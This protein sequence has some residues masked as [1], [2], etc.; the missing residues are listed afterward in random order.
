MSQPSPV[1]RT[2]GIFVR[3][4]EG[5]HLLLALMA[6]R[7]RKTVAGMVRQV[8]LQDAR[9]VAKDLLARSQAADAACGAH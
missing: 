4:T 6:R 8:A 1:P 3:V 9:T 2:K 7:R 5:E